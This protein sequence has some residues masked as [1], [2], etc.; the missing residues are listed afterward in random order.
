[1][2]TNHLYSVHP[3][4]ESNSVP[5]DKIANVLRYSLDGTQFI[6]EWLQTPDPSVVTLNHTDALNLTR[7]SDWAITD[8]V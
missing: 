5:Q 7:T 2:G 8:L 1:M 3:A 6:V 4:L